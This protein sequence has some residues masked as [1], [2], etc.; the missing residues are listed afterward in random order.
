M[1]KRFDEPGVSSSV[2]RRRGVGWGNHA[3][4]GCRKE[5]AAQ[6]TCWLMKTRQR[7]CEMRLKAIAAVATAS[8]GALALAACTGGGSSGGASS[9]S[10]AGAGPVTLSYWAWGT[11]QDGMV[12]AWN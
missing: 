12:E 6:P 11:A 9:S 4:R 1:S 10:T 8:V 3:G 2:P 5:P 7:R